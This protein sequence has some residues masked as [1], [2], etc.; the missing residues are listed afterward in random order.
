MLMY[1]LRI[2]KFGGYFAWG[3]NLELNSLEVRVRGREAWE[4]TVSVPCR[5]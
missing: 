1:V 4:S 2:L 5:P 3:C